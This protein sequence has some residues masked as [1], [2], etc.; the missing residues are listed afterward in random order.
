VCFFFFLARSLIRH[1]FLFLIELFLSFSTFDGQL[2]SP[3]P[4]SDGH[5]GNHVGFSSI[6]K[7]LPFITASFGRFG[8]LDGPDHLFDA[9]PTISRTSLFF[10]LFLSFTYSF[11]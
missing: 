6:Y 11:T 7:I 5:V 8:L 3:F 10:V 2:S 1:S 4:T 9:F